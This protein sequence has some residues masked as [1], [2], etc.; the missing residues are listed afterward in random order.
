[1]G[2]AN[3]ACSVAAKNRRRPSQQST[4]T[5]QQKT[6]TTNKLTNQ[7][8]TTS[9]TSITSSAESVR[10]VRPGISGQGGEKKVGRNYFYSFFK[11]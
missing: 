9:E 8:S 2:V 11:K 5:V 6:D 4:I 10:S 7:G 1:M 3:L